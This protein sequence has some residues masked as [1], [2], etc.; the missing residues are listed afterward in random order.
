[1]FGTGPRRPGASATSYVVVRGSRGLGGGREGGDEPGGRAGAE[2]G[3]AGGAA[4]AAPE[5]L[6]SEVC[7]R[8]RQNAVAPKRGRAAQNSTVVKVASA[9]VSGD[10]IST[11][12]AYSHKA[13]ALWPAVSSTSVFCRSRSSSSTRGPLRGSDLGRPTFRLLLSIV[14]SFR[15]WFGDKS[16][17]ARRGSAGNLRADLNQRNAAR[18]RARRAPAGPARRHVGRL[19]M[20]VNWRRASSTIRRYSR[21]AGPLQVAQKN[22]APETPSARFTNVMHRAA[23]PDPGPITCIA[24]SPD[25]EHALSPASCDGTRTELNTKASCVGVSARALELADPNWALPATYRPVAGSRAGIGRAVR[26]V[27]DSPQS[28]R[29]GTVPGRRVAAPG[30]EISK[31]CWWRF[32]S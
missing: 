15:D 30:A 18:D 6:T 21:P 20:S 17:R 31:A 11:H 27:G 5:G 28:G 3:A 9:V 22:A 13:R 2:A 29:R 4:G 32:G 16:Q 26:A 7:R 10:D 23:S 19:R 25:P 12:A 14:F 8:S 24:R 1:M